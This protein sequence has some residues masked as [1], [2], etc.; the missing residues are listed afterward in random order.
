MC[1]RHPEPGAGWPEVNPDT[2][3]DARDSQCSYC[4]REQGVKP[5]HKVTI[6]SSVSYL[7]ER[8]FQRQQARYAAMTGGAA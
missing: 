8:C 5:M 2:Y 6:G 7:C 4:G 1:S 3:S